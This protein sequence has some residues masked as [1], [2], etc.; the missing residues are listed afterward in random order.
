MNSVPLLLL[1]QYFL[2][3]LGGILHTCETEVLMTNIF[4]S[5]YSM[6]CPNLLCQ[7]SREAVIQ[8]Q[9]GSLV[10]RTI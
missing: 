6:F 2:Q 1:Y 9:S 3:S 4:F 8:V 5:P 10:L 7:L